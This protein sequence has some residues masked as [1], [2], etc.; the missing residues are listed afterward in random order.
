MTRARAGVRGADEREAVAARGAAARGLGA[1]RGTAHA[2]PRPSLA[3]RQKTATTWGNHAA[4][5]NIILIYI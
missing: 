5:V 1:R 4:Q 2:R 3:A